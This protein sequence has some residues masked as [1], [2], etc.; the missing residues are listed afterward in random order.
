[1]ADLCDQ[2]LLW[3][4]RDQGLRKCGLYT[5]RREQ[6]ACDLRRPIVPDYGPQFAGL[7]RVCGFDD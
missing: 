6:D 2:T 1:M 4:Q 7:K 5:C 3:C